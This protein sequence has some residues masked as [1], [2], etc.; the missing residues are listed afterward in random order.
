[1]LHQKIDL[2]L[3][4][5]SIIIADDHPT[6]RLGL[7]DLISRFS[8]SCQ[9]I[10]NVGDGSEAFK[11]C[12]KMHP[13][14]LVLDLN[15][16]KGGPSGYTVISKLREAGNQVKI[17]VLS[18]DEFLDATHV[19]N[20]GAD[21]CLDKNAPIE[22]IVSTLDNLSQQFQPSLAQKQPSTITSSYQIASSSNPQKLLDKLT[23]RE[24]EVLSELST[25]ASNNSIA[26]KLSIDTRTV[27]N[28]LGSVYEKLELK[29]RSEAI[30]FVHQNK[31]LVDEILI[32]SH[33]NF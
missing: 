26:L 1:M 3:K 2:T 15:F 13:D 22:E 32:K 20:L 9:V 24:L 31:I 4:K 25:G 33:K 19:I 5:N 27:N 17:L 6:F 28:H 21:M 16:A 23:K 30:V 8:T 18:G 12:L 14:I 11:L 7:S 10:A 29:N